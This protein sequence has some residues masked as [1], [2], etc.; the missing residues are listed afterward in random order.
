MGASGKFGGKIIFKN[1]NGITVISSYP[2]MSRVKRSEK[3]KAENVKFKEANAY[4]NLVLKTPELYDFYKARLKGLQRVNNLAIRD[5]S[6]PPIVHSITYHCEE[7][8][9]Y[10]KASD[11]FMVTHVDI[12]IKAMNGTLLQE[13]QALKSQMDQ[14]TFIVNNTSETEFSVEAKAY[15]LPGHHASLVQYIPILPSANLR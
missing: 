8:C 7:K 4:A 2:D 1:Y 11:D 14:W 10:V 13:G 15:D 5:F 3:Q 6:K 9:I 12:S